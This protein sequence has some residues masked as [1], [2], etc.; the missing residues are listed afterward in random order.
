[1]KPKLLVAA[2]FATLI[3]VSAAFGASSSIS[4]HLRHHDD[5]YKSD[6]AKKI[7]EIV[8][9]YQSLHGDW[10]KNI[11]ALGVGIG[12]FGVLLR[13]GFAH[14]EWLYG[15]L[16]ALLVFALYFY[17]R[18]KSAAERRMAMALTTGLTTMGMATTGMVMPASA[19]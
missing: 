17:W 19:A 16:L 10:P 12:A 15:V 3:S 7:A 5:W 4:K 13:V 14:D 9:S 1:M 2:V 6:E 18:T 11:A 8:L